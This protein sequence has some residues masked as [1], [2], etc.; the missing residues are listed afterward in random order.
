VR[1]RNWLDPALFAAGTA[2]AVFMVSEAVDA[3]DRGSLYV[4]LGF[5]AVAAGL[6]L[7]SLWALR[8]DRESDAKSPKA[9]TTTEP[10]AG[11]RLFLAYALALHAAGTVVLILAMVAVFSDGG[12]WF[13]V[14]MAA[15]CFVLL[16]VGHVKRSFLDRHVV[17]SES[18]GRQFVEGNLPWSREFDRLL[19]A[20]GDATGRNGRRLLL[21]SRVWFYG[22]F[23]VWAVCVV[24][25]GARAA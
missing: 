9:A 7:R 8:P 6:L 1:R 25:I 11:P 16:L 4:S 10:S 12:G 19:V 24:I 14:A 21:L 18:L 17:V 15:F 23:G 2:F 5:A 22:G 20:A 13:A 3:Q